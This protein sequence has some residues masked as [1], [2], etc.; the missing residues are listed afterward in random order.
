M[1]MTQPVSERQKNQGRDEPPQTEDGSSLQTA[2]LA[3]SNSQINTLHYAVLSGEGFYGFRRLF[4]I[5]DI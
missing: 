2:L 4:L 5:L 3:N 1:G